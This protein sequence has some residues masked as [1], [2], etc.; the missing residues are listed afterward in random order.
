MT[1]VVYHTLPALKF[2]IQLEGIIYKFCLFTWLV[3]VLVVAWGI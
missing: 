1:E 2:S 3:R